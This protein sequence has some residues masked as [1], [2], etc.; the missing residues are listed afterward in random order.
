MPWL[1]RPSVGYPSPVRRRTQRTIDN[2][3][4]PGHALFLSAICFRKCFDMRTACGS[5]SP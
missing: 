4:F 2:Q 1:N 5:P 3:H